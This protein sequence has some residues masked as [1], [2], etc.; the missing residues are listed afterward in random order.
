MVGRISVAPGSHLQATEHPEARISIWILTL[1]HIEP[2]F[3]GFFVSR[4]ATGGTWS[5]A[6]GIFPGSQKD[7]VRE[8][9]KLVAA[10]SPLLKSQAFSNV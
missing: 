2:G 8:R 5:K 1:E 10:P 6:N 9:K 7:L 4:Q 3:F